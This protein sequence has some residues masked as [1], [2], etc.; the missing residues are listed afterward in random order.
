[1]LWWRTLS[2][3]QG[4]TKNNAGSLQLS[5]RKT[6]YGLFSRDRRLWKSKLSLLYN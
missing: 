5:S 6:K 2:E 1:M 4:P 3:G